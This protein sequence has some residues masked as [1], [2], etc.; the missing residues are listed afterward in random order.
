MRLVFSV[1]SLFWLHVRT[2]IGVKIFASD[3]RANDQFGSVVA[4]FGGTAVVGSPLDDD[5]G[6][7]TGLKTESVSFY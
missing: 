1:L 3:P 4:V 5:H 2:S 6:S 7:A